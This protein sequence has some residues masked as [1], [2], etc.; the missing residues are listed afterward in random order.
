[1]LST[2]VLFLF[3]NI[4]LLLHITATKKSIN[5]V[6][7]ARSFIIITPSV[8]ANLIRILPLGATGKRDRTRT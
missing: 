2:I 1:M 6:V 7:G 5:R 4:T 8:K 3:Y